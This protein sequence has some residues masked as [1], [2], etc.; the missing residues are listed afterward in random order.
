MKPNPVFKGLPKELKNPEMFDKIEEQL[1]L[2][3]D[4]THKTVKSFVS[5]AWCNEQRLKRS[6]KIVELG[7]KDYAQ[8]LEWRKIM[9]IIKSN[10]N[11]VIKNV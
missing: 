5:C 3:S 6:A 9:W 10:K 2:K 7:F 1:S 11:F 4:H 8:Y